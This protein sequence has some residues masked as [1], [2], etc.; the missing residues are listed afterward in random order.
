MPAIDDGVYHL[1]GGPRGPGSWLPSPGWGTPRR[2]SGREA[3]RTSTSSTG[4]Y[5]RKEVLQFLWAKGRQKTKY[6]EMK[7]ETGVRGIISPVSDNTM[8]V[9]CIFLSHVTP[10][11]TRVQEAKQALYRRARGP[12]GNHIYSHLSAGGHGLRRLSRERLGQ[13]PNNAFE[14]HDEHWRLW[15]VGVVVNLAANLVLVLTCS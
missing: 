6:Q 14:L 13:V 2:R 3:S 9:P 4:R 7:H 10:D 8:I 12:R 11:Q 5:G 15:V 1:S